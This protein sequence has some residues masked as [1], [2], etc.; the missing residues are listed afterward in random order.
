MTMHLHSLLTTGHVVASSS[1]ESDGT[2]LAWALLLSGFLFYGL[3]YARYRNT[4][5]RHHHEAET[6]ASMHDVR[7]SDTYRRSLKGVSN[8][9]MEGANNTEVRGARRGLLESMGVPR[10]LGLPKL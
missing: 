4:D 5:K 10:S 3:M 1:S 8:R 7:A 6:R 9:T 2:G